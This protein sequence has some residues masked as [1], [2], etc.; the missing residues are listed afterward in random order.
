MKLHGKVCEFNPHQVA[1][2]NTTRQMLAA[3]IPDTECG[4]ST[5]PP[6]TANRHCQ[7]D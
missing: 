1:E 3:G 7:L 5:S 6:G 2:V 4:K